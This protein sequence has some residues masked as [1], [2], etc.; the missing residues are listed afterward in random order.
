MAE[1]HPTQ[2][3]L[4]LAR[5][6]I[7]PKLRAAIQQ[8]VQ[9]NGRVVLTG[10]RVAHDDPGVSISIDVRPVQSDG[11]ELF[12]VCFVDEPTSPGD[13]ALS[14]AVRDEPA[15]A[16]LQRE[17]EATRIELQSAIR[18]LEISGEEQKAINQEALSVNE[19]FQST[20]EELLASK[21]ELQSLN[22]EL[23]ALNGQLQETLERQRTTS[24]DLQ[25]VLY[26]TDV[27]TVFLDAELNIRFFTPATRSLFRVIPGDIGRPLSDLNSLAAD[28]MLQ[29][30]ARAVLESGTPVEREIEAGSGAWFVRRILPYRTQEH[31][32]EGVVITFVDITE[33]RRT[34][35]ALQ[36]AKRE[37][38]LATIAK[39]RFLAI[40]SHDLR[41]PLQTLALLQG[42][43]AKTVQGDRQREL[44]SRLDA[45]LGGMA[46]VLNALLDITQIEAG[47]VRAEKLNF[48]IGG[49]LERLRGEFAYHAQAHDLELHM[50]P[51]AA[52]VHSDPQLLEQMIRNLLSNA[53][54]YTKGG[55]VLLGCRRRRGML[56]I[57]VWDTGVGIRADELQAIFDEYHQVDN[58]T[59]E[60]SRGF[61][62]GLSIV[63]RLGDLLNHHIRV[64]S[65][66]GRGSVFSIEVP[67]SLDDLGF[68][69][70][71]RRSSA[72]A[73]A[74]AASAVRK[75]GA[76]LVVEDDPDMRGL[77]ELLLKEEG[78]LVASA[79]D[80]FKA[81]DMIT[82]QL[83]HAD[84]L[85][86]DY[87]LPN[88]MDGLLLVK[89]VRETLRRDIPVI[90]LTGDISTE[91]LRDIAQQNC[92]QLHKPV[93]A[94]H[95]TRAIQR[96]IPERRSVPPAAHA[97]DPNLTVI[98]VVDDDSNIGQAIRQ[99]FEEEGRAVVTY[100]SSEAFLDGYRPGGRGCLLIDAYLP[101]MDGFEL[102]QTLRQRGL[103]LP[104][105]MITGKSDVSMAVRAMR[106]GASDFIEKPIGSA[107]LIASVERALDQAQDSSKRLARWQAAA[108]RIG[109]LTSRQHQIMDLVL[110][111][112]PS[113]NIAADLGISQRTVENH[114]ASIMKKTGSKSLPALARLAI[115]A[116]WP[117][118]EETPAQD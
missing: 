39:S 37:A 102:L 73:P 78:Y 24:N 69:Q 63:K 72:A 104:S 81:L 23:T 22:E 27:A 49:L 55:R 17:L 75:G 38:E 87:N 28:S 97:A 90:V 44:V 64:R 76:I 47:I 52:S 9:S 40:A 82:K 41:Q 1:G 108:D 113:K 112:H 18:N 57:E 10:G 71:Q 94:E 30:D 65:Q 56:S 36:A 85:L 45:T 25:N 68:H 110:A 4:A 100:A 59:R 88:G 101:G 116:A 79:A 117:P 26:S 11:E 105:I 60:A 66:P 67:L 35:D 103:Q 15:I 33:Q 70:E 46:G 92:L 106:A 89:R 62:L 86:A 48:P 6:E 111:G 77:L 16:R 21:E 7:R 51:C 109:K 118:A 96:L 19:E 74:A 115:A 50:V 93:K 43:L 53:L 107:D 61:G 99:I 3:L 8:A 114:R 31:R 20:N 13:Q 5:R 14:T 42:L 84:L 54:K 98:H 58:A 2:D 91:T 95:L 83:F 80:G 29:D 32:V 12:L 34:G